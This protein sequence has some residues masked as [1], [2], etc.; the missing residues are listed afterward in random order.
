M[1]KLKPQNLYWTVVNV[2]FSINIGNGNNIN[3]SWVGIFTHQGHRSSLN[4]VSN[5]VSEYNSVKGR[6]WSD[7]GQL[8][9]CWKISIQQMTKFMTHLNMLAFVSD[10]FFWLPFSVYNPLFV[11]IYSLKESCFCPHR[12]I[13]SEKVFFCQQLVRYGTICGSGGEFV[14]CG[15]R[16]DG[17]MGQWNTRLTAPWEH[18]HVWAAK[19]KEEFAKIYF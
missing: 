14:N 11:L 9:I 18:T 2:F 5:W 17:T 12:D 6:Q 16:K 13:S 3:K 4:K 1:L 15:V 10:I 19:L 7:L 8:K